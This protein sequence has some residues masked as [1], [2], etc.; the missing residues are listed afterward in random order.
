MRNNLIPT[1][2]HGMFEKLQEKLSSAAFVCLITDIWSNT[3][4]EAKIGV[5]VSIINTDFER[6]T[7]IIGLNKMESP[8]T[9]EKVKIGIVLSNPPGY[10]ET[11]FVNKIKFLKDA[12]FEVYLFVDK[13]SIKS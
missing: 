11:F 6:E 4:M 13:F 9:A 12:G 8:H 2:Y 10:S 5:G 7:F 1:L 3:N